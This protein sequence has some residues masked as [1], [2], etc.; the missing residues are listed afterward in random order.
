MLLHLHGALARFGGP[1]LWAAET[2]RKA[3]ALLIANFPEAREI[4]RAHEWRLVSPVRTGE[5]DLDEGMVD[6]RVRELH[7]VPMPAGSK[8]GGG[9]V[10]IILGVVLIAIAVFV[11]GAQMLGSV[12]FSMVMG[13]VSQMLS[14]TP[15]VAS[16]AP[17]EPA[18]Q[19]PSYL[20]SSPSNTTEQGQPVPLVF[21]RCITGSRVV[22][23]GV[24]S[25]KI[26]PA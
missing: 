10:K 2:P 19:R 13:G 9:P 12:G 8:S 15:K 4:I 18:D 7:L 23:G 6:L 16:Y 17:R 14:P 3:I 24:T 25:E 26:A 20:S 1:F 5:M 21:G 11:P 22:S